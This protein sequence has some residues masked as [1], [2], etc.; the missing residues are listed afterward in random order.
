[1]SLQPEAIAYNTNASGSSYF[2]TPSIV[3]AT[4]PTSH[5]SVTYGGGN[6]GS[7]GNFNIPR[8]GRYFV[9]FTYSIG[10]STGTV[11]AGNM[12]IFAIADFPSA[13]SLASATIN[14]NT[15]VVDGTGKDTVF[16]SATYP[17]T[18][19]AGIHTLR[20][21]AVLANAGDTNTYDLNIGPIYF[22]YL[23]N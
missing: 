2:F 11:T 5:I 17:V 13:T 10:L 1:M 21:S 4:P 14:T 16:G 15:L 22:Q 23:D 19:T 6:T 7:V 8:T 20:V 18:L 9:N 3:V 12:G